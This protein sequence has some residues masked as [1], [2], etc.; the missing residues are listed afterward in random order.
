MAVAFDI[1]SAASKRNSG[2][3]RYSRELWKRLSASPLLDPIGM[4]STSVAARLFS[5]LTVHAG[6]FD[7]AHF[8]TFPPLPHIRARRT[9]V[10]TV[11]DLTWW[12]YPET[13]SRLGRR[14]YA[15][16]AERAIDRCHLV[17]HSATVRDE[18]CADFNRSPDQVTV[19]HPGVAIRAQ[20]DSSQLPARLRGRPYLL[21]V[22]TIEPR[23]NL[24]RLA[25]AYRASGLS[26]EIP[27]VLVGRRAWGP[28]PVGVDIVTDCDDRMLGALY[29]FAL[30]VVSPS[31]YE[32]FGLPVLEAM[33][34]GTPVAC[35]AIPVF[36]EVTG[37]HAL[38]FNPLDVDS[39]T[40]ALEKLASAPPQNPAATKWAR[41]YTWD[42]AAADLL[43]LY[44][45]LE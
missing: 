33:S 18:L 16:L 4:P 11:H 44:G 35:S 25:Q 37:G 24:E 9:T 45:S 2:W 32:G 7:V 36:K 40:G 14:Y 23:K 8:P 38:M 41:S 13:A 43:R 42:R 26:P 3:E 21:V 31:L 20:T 27:L 19:I 39:I 1:R 15:P 30:G 34:L 22:A 6:R 29:H 28:E 12:R 5:D 17:V 10:F